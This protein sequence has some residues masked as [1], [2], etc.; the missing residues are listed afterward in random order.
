MDTQPD[1]FNRDIL[2]HLRYREHPEQHHQLLFLT[3]FWFAGILLSLLASESLSA[4]AL[5]TG[6]KK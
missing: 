4:Q 1:T 5:T 6:K 2:G 3:L